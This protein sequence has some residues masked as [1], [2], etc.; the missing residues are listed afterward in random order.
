MNLVVKINRSNRLPNLTTLIQYAI[1][2]TEKHKNLKGIEKR[3]FA[4]N[5]IKETIALLPNGDNQKFLQNA[6]E[7]GNIADL[8]DLTIEASNG[9]L[10]INKKVNIFLRCLL[11]CF[12]SNQFV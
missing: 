3:E 11:A 8:I 10:D 4:L 7:N 12:K 5:M 1:E 6:Y 9:K 2:L